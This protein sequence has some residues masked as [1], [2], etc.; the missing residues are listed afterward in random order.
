MEF[1][2]AQQLDTE[3]CSGERAGKATQPCAL[4]YLFCNKNKTLKRV[5]AW[6]YIY[7]DVCGRA[8]K[9]N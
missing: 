6:V 3:V 5:R 8:V 4:S 9:V 7:I 2:A 1:T